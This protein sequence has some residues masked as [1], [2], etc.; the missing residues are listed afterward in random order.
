MK[1]KENNGNTDIYIYIYFK[2]SFLFFL[3]SKIIEH[4]WLQ[5]FKTVFYYEK[6][7]EEGKHGEHMFG[8]FI[9]LF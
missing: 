9:F 8:S 4:V 5:F 2:L 3:F 6:H 1:N 7:G